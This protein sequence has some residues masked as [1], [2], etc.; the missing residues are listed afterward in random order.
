MA[1]NVARWRSDLSPSGQARQ[2]TLLLYGSLFV[3]L[4]PFCFGEMKPFAALLLLLLAAE[5]WRRLRRQRRFGGIL[6]AE[7]SRRWRWQGRD[8]WIA[9]SPFILPF[10]V[11]LALRAEQGRGLS[12]WL[13]R[14][15]MS[16]ANWRA[17]RRL[18]AGYQ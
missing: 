7:E 6:T 1:R 16:E 3:G 18:L 13:M 10:G 11:L 2:I 15:S 4:L 14:D 5:L 17:L 8:Y 12:L 9:R